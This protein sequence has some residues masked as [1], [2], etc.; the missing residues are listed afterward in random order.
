MKEQDLVSV[1]EIVTCED[2]TKMLGNTVEVSVSEAVEGIQMD[3]YK[4]PM[5]TRGV[6][7][8]EW[9]SAGK[10]EAVEPEEVVTAEAEGEDH[11]SGGN[12]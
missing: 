3:R 2:G 4:H 1:T 12:G 7:P 10:V 6:V 5:F 9:A 11:D 8:P